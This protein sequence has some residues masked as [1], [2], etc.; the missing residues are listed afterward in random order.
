MHLPKISG[1]KMWTEEGIAFL[2]M[3]FKKKNSNRIIYKW[4]NGKQWNKHLIEGQYMGNTE[5]SSMNMN[6]NNYHINNCRFGWTKASTLIIQ[7]F[8]A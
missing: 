2:L 7:Q 1:I 5:Y 6:G 8:T 4:E 3:N